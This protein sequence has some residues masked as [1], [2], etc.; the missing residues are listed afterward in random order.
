MNTDQTI[1]DFLETMNDPD[2]AVSE[3]HEYLEMQHHYTA[4]I[5][6]VRTKL[7]ILNDGFALTHDHNPIHNIESRI[8]S[9]RSMINKLKSRGLEVSI[10]SAR[11]NLH[12]IAGIRVVCCYIDDVY[13]VGEMLSQQDDV[14]VLETKDYIKNPKPNGYRSLH[15]VISI[16]IFLSTGLIGVPVEVQIRTVAMDVWAS[17]E[18]ELRYKTSNSIPQ[19]ANAELLLCATTLSVLDDRMQKLFHEAT[20][21][22]E[23]HKEP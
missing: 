14:T 8:K 21:Q 10:A 19:D 22:N 13:A 16:P 18:H 12:D 11:A 6:E 17:L 9:T 20:E 7:E 4:A 5:K 15:L 3:I 23:D 1:K 2:I